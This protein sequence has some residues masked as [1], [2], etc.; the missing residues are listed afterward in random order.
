[1]YN[2]AVLLILR[3]EFLST[4]PQFEHI[5]GTTDRFI[6]KAQGI[7]NKHTTRAE[8]IKTKTSNSGFLF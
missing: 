4:F 5:N 2:S 1:M 6:E 7:H 3:I 8:K